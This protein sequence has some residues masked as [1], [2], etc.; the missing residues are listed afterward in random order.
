MPEASAAGM[1]AA[2]EAM[3][4][5]YAFPATPKELSEA[6]NPPAADESFITLGLP[7]VFN[8]NHMYLI[9]KRLLLSIL[10]KKPL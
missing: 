3:N 1:A 2:G 9:R 10:A 8:Q 4:E 7:L 5:D 6:G